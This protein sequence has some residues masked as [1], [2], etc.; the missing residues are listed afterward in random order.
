MLLPIIGTKFVFLVGFMGAGKTTV[1][2]ALAQA[3]AREFIDLD[4]LIVAVDGRSIPDIFVQ[5]GEAYF[6]RV[7]S[8]ILFSLTNR[9]G[10]V[11]ALGGGTFSQPMNKAFVKQNGISIWLN[12]SLEEILKRVPSDGSR[13]LL[14]SPKQVADLLVRRIP[15]YQEATIKLDASH[16][17]VDEVVERIIAL[18]T[19]NP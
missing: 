16:L 3:L 13:P 2:R 1:G 15:D 7:E 9:Q 18:L 10:A 8:R 5:S 12:C 6:R 19:T 14:Q 11:V 17:T 4:D